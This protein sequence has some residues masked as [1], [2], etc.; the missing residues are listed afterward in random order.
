VDQSLIRGGTHVGHRIRAGQVWR[1]PPAKRGACLHAALAQR[2]GSCIRRLGG[3]RSR[4]MQ[5]TRFLRNP[6]VTPP[7][8]ASYAAAG[9]AARAAGRDV[10]VIQDTTEVSLGG[11]RA[12]ANGYG[13]IGKGGALRGLVSHVVLAVDA[14][15]GAVL[16]LIEAKVWNRD[17]GKAT[18]RRS[19]ATSDKE[20]Q[21]WID[22]AARAAEVLAG[23]RSITI[24]SDRESDVYEYFARR[25]PNVHVIARACQDRQIEAKDNSARLL[26]EFIDGLPVQGRFS[27]D[28]P[29]APGRKARAAELEIRFSPV[30]LR[31]PQHGAADLPATVSLTVV[32]VREIS[33]AQDSEP[34]HWRLLT[35]QQVPDFAAA[36]QVVLSYRRRWTIEVYFHTLKT[37]GIDIEAA[38]ISKPSAMMN[39][40]AAGC[41]AS[42]TIMQL[43]R[44]R[45]GNTE[46][47]ITD[48]FD[49]DD[50]PVLEALS[51]ELEG[52]TERQK[53]PHPKGSLAFAAWVIARLG[54]WTGYYGKPG[55]LV[56]RRG[57][58]E[59][60]QIKRGV[61]LKLRPRD[62]SS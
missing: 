42:V 59:F 32:D 4:E 17:K 56:M 50:Q 60:R 27:A 22:G 18:S 29:A 8:I 16:G 48:A 55:P 13:P 26:F 44:A 38:D 14:A 43:V 31:K 62:D 30:V 46:Q 7:E 25:S 10:L 57:I 51:T 36:Q 3:K 47:K 1:S 40:V 58:E 39:L 41:V 45:D 23:A 54:G 11:R 6:R 21:R 34:I 20:S 49:P 19:R 61:A 24:V 53:N 35:S 37:G 9:T 28:I 33:E 2:P 12:R 52:K 5:F 15:T